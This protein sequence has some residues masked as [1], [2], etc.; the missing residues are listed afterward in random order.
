MGSASAYTNFSNEP[1]DRFKC[2]A[3]TADYV[4]EPDCYEQQFSSTSA[5]TIRDAVGLF[6]FHAFLKVYL[7][8]DE[9][10]EENIQ[11]LKSSPT[12]TIISRD[13]RPK[14]R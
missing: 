6:F 14:D 11:F 3:F 8:I 7:A 13:T 2:R 4:L 10:N 9:I 12:R 5:A 1:N